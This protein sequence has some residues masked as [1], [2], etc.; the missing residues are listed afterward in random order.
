MKTGKVI[1]GIMVGTG[2]GV[3]LGLLFAPERGAEAR[4]KLS[5]VGKEYADMIKKKFDKTLDGITERFDKAKE[6]VADFS[7]LTRNKEERMKK[8]NSVEIH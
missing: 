6:E 7:H 8:G 1:L 5:K 2:A 3:L 4:A